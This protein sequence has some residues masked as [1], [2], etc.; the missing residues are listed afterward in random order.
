LTPF[1]AIVEAL[2]PWHGTWP[3]GGAGERASLPPWHRM[4]D[5]FLTALLA[6]SDTKNSLCGIMAPCDLRGL[7]VHGS[8]CMVLTHTQASVSDHSP[9]IVVIIIINNN[10]NNN[11]NE[12]VPVT[13]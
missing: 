10:N 5:A 9:C 2:M 7:L 8:V 12:T 1:L 4:A 13:H 3:V 6:C 11:K